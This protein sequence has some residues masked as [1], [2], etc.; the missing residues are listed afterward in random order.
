MKLD[1]ADREMSLRGLPVSGGIAQGHAFCMLHTSPTNIPFFSVPEAGIAAEKARL[2]AALD[3]LVGE[4][5]GL[6]TEV[7]ARVGEAQAN[8]FV[9]QKMMVLDPMLREQMCGVIEGKRLNAE[10]AVEQTLDGYETLLSEVDNDY[11]RERASD[12]G[13]IRRRIQGL[14]QGEKKRSPE[15]RLGINGFE[16]PVVIVAEELTP[17]DTVGLDE[18]RVAGFV[19]ERGGPASH[20]AILARALGIPAVSGVKRV[21][22]LLTHG[23]HVL[24]NGT[25]GEVIVSPSP[26]TLSLHPAVTGEAVEPSVVEPVSGLRVM[27]NIN[28]ATEVDRANLFK[29]EGIGLYRTEFE[30]LAARRFLTEDE[31]Y[32]RY[33]SLLRGM[34]EAPIHIRLLDL[35]S[36]KAASFLNIPP[37]DNPCLGF[38]GARLLEDRPEWLATQARAIARASRIRPVCVTYPMIVDTE[39]FLRLREFFLQS[40]SGCNA[41]KICHG[42]MFEVPAACLASRELMEAADFGSIGTNDLIQYLLAVDRNNDLVAQDYDAD[43]VALWSIIGQIAGNAR[44]ANKP[45]ALCGEMGGQAKYLPR[46]IQAGINSVSVSIRLMAAARVAADRYFRE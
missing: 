21:Q 18:K 24:L 46:L 34:P 31:Q 14:L 15:D 22:R 30:L 44:D 28:L 23:Q 11:I 35:G 10:T 16:G 41:G 13:E 33:A 25:T 39:Q 12:I 6:I 26:S 37:E 5:D 42:V 4:L 1:T 36:D 2:L 9:A 43:H 29:A 45:L 38:R 17:S 8:I 3:A 32:E 19:T 40:I 27:A 7:A 20:A